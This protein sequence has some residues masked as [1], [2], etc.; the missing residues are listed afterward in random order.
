MNQAFFGSFWH[1]F[2]HL[3]INRLALQDLLFVF[4]FVS[5][6]VKGITAMTGSG[7]CVQ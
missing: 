2:G 6:T 1:L 5:V 3:N 4:D 7:I